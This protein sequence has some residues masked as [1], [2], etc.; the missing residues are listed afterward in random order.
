MSSAGA[1]SAV[2]H[3]TGTMPIA[4]ETAER[5]IGEGLRF[6]PWVD[7]LP[8]WREALA[9][10]PGATLYQHERWLEALRSCY[11]SDLRVATLHRRGKLRAAAVFAY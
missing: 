3:S 6:A 9:T 11:A 8:L 2:T 10:L 5:D 4:I 1:V 7:A